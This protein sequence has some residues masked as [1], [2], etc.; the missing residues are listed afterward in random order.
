MQCPEIAQNIQ[1]LHASAL[2]LAECRMAHLRECAHLLHREFCETPHYFLQD[3]FRARYRE[4]MQRP[5]PPTEEVPPPHKN[6]I[7]RQNQFLVHDNA[8]YFVR[9]LLSFYRQSDKEPISP[10]IFCT[11]SEPEQFPYHSD[12]IAY[13][14]NNFSDEAFRKFSHVFPDAPASYCDDFQ[15]VCE[16]VSLGHAKYGILPWENARDGR[17]KTFEALAWRYDLKLILLC[18][19]PMGEDITQFALLGRRVQS[20]DCG[21][22]KERSF[23]SLRIRFA[24]TPPW[25]APSLSLLLS[26]SSYFGSQLKSIASSRT[27]QAE[28]DLTFSTDSADIA[29]FLCY[30]TL[31]FPQF[32]PIGLY[33][34]LKT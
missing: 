24:A 32:I 21:R 2:T 34:L 15:S 5:L 22:Q 20:I 10:Q 11:P 16:E 1:S 4:E 9:A 8:V 33:S 13:L 18:E 23:F 30:L 29:A 25:H 27:D 7:L 14:K 3:A 12:R 17:L 26:A 31:E 6:D 19:V 28:Y